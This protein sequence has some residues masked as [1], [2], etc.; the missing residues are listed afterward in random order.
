MKEPNVSRNARTYLLALQRCARSA[1]V[2][3]SRASSNEALEFAR[4]VWT[5]WNASGLESRDISPRTLEKIYGA[6]IRVL[7]L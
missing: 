7:T 6:M 4:L 1:S 2:W 3:Q 5:D